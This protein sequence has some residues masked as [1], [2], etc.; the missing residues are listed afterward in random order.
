MSMADPAPASQ[1]TL[2]LQV[3]GVGSKGLALVLWVR[4]LVPLLQELLGLSLIHI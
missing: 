1:M 2:A 3:P 4:P